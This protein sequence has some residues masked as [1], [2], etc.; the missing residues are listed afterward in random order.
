MKK[1]GLLALLP[2]LAMADVTVESVKPLSEANLISIV[3]NPQ[4]P[5][6]LW[7]VGGDATILKSDDMGL[8]WAQVTAPKG[9]EKLQFR[10]IVVVNDKLVYAMT[11]GLKGDSRV[12]RTTDGGL[13]WSLDH[14]ETNPKAFFNCMDL[15][16]NG[17][18][19]MFGDSFDG[20][21]FL[22]KRDDN[23]WQKIAGTPDA[24][25]HEG[26]FAS[27]GTCLATANDKLII[28]TGAAAK[29]RLIVGDESGFKTIDAPHPK[30]EQAGIFTVQ[31]ADEGVWVFGGNLKEPKASPGRAYYY[32]YSDWAE[33][34]A[35][36]NVG[37]I[38]GSDWVSQG[39]HSRL[40][41][42]SPAG[43][44]TSTDKGKTW[45]FVAENNYWAVHCLN[46]EHC[47]AVGTKG[48]IDHFYFK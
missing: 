14:Q 24:Q 20:K 36:T 48:R 26:G 19:Y 44:S 39:K 30:G 12:Y 13:S 22:R 10:D 6:Q 23:G 17:D 45:S 9:I 8:H 46:T 43:A 15:A 7:T 1:L 11:V 5:S 16:A 28:G 38:Y 29:P 4:K 31:I 3:A 41:T 21:L 40:V 2:S 18:V 33:I 32:N 37:A 34:S 27:S 42:T 47:V 25:D 35:P